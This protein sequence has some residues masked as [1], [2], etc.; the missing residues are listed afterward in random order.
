MGV[1]SLI[2]SKKTFP[3]PHI[4]IIVACLLVLGLPASGQFIEVGPVIGAVSDTGFRVYVRPAFPAVVQVE[5]LIGPSGICAA[6]A[7]SP[8]EMMLSDTGHILSVQGLVPNVQYRLR[9][10][11]DERPDTLRATV[12]T[13]PS[14]GETGSFTFVAG[15]CQ[16]TANMK[17][18]DRI[19]ELRPYF[20][21]HT[22]DYTYPDYQI[23]PDYA[24]DYGLVAHSYR[25]RYLEPRMREMLRG[26]PLDYVYDDNDYVGSNGTR[27]HLNLF[28]FV[29]CQRNP[30]RIRGADFRSVRIPDEW[31][32]NVIRGYSE[33][34]PH[35]PLPDTSEGIYHSFRFANAEFFF[36]D[37]CSAR[38]FPLEHTFRKKGRRW[39]F[40]PPADNR[41][42]GE[43]QMQWLRN[44]LQR[45]TAHWKFIVSGVPL[46]RSVR[47]L[48]GAGQA[49]QRWRM[50][51][52]SGFHLM[53]AM[54]SYWAAAPVEQ[55]DFLRFLK[56]ENI[57]NV[58]VISGDTHYCALD[59]GRNAGLPELCASGLSVSPD[60]RLL[61]Y[62][63]LL[64][65]LTMRF[66]VK[67]GL[68][69]HGGT[70]L[71]NRA[72]KNAFGKITLVGDQKVE[73][74]VVDEDGN[75]IARM[76]VYSQ[77]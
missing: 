13:F 30:H 53:Q 35:Y 8:R 25:R 17:T 1:R 31:R 57:R 54:S 23:G 14:P 56:K 60:T 65:Q 70:G 49:F 75:I 10:F 72:H 44:G 52:Y 4:L 47:K 38:E 68:W 9:F 62:L 43:K 50:K 2:F 45:S 7:E 33:F 42:F 32:R 29:P 66:R 3:V 11:V 64:G 69:N 12:R 28:D 15:S 39:I 19:A 40:D 76:D 5:A 27:S 37:R 6:R 16:E 58:I 36:V 18:F 26:V 63:D 48:I 34:F 46:N 55:E 74:S 20:F 61:H 67:K 77:P 73:L 71:G 51:G 24:G 59:D 22:G 21:L 41:V